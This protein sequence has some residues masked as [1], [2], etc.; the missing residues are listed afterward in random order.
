VAIFTINAAY[1]FRHRRLAPWDVQWIQEAFPPIAGPLTL[2]TSGL[3]YI[4]P[5]DFVLGILRQIWHNGFGHPAGFLGMYSRTGWWYYFPVAFSLKT[6]I[7]F[8]LLSLTALGWA[9]A[10]AIRK[11]D[12]NYVWMLA[13]FTIYTV[14]VLFSRIDIGVRYYLPAYSFLFILGGA[15]LASL[16]KSRNA[17]RLGMLVAI[18][19]LAW[20]GIEAGRAFPNHMSYMNQL[21]F[22]K[23]HWWYLS[24][25]NVEW[26]DDIP[27]LAAYLRARGETRVRAY[28]LGDFLVLHHYGVE[29]LK[30]A[31]EGDQPPE[32]TRYAAIGAS[33]LNGST[34]PDMM[35]DGRPATEDERVN[36][37]DKY[38]HKT[39]EAVFGGSIYLYREDD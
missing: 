25:S 19:S 36:F 12:S 5:A 13:P 7:P 9:G 20:I 6:T 34:M 30:T 33:F 24:D 32:K 1:F 31:D 18:V 23:P 8:L 39:P 37:L 28:F 3:S 17:V 27:A 29:P 38:R 16:F 35:I 15:L 11:R 2:I 22:G 26:G 21:A 4:V 10:Q 14:Y